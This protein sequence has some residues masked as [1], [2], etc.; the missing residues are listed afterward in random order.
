MAT[1][2]FRSSIAA[3]VVTLW[4]TASAMA[5]D[6]EPVDVGSGDILLV[7]SGAFTESDDVTDLV[8]AVSSHRPIAVTFNSPGGNLYSAM[9]HGRMIRA[10]GLSTIQG[11]DLECV[12]AC[13]LAFLGGVHRIAAPGSIGVHR[14]SF[15]PGSL[16][17]SDEATAA[18]QQ[19][20]A[21][22]LAFLREMD[23]D[24][25]LLQV[26]MEYDNS[27][28]RYLSASE[29]LRMRVITEASADSSVAQESPS[30][31][32]DTPLSVPQPDASRDYR[33]DA[34]S[35][36]DGIISAHTLPAASGLAILSRGYSDPAS[37]FGEVTSLG[38]IM[39]DKSSYFD[40]WP[41]RSYQVRPHQT[42]VECGQRMC[43][44]R[45]TYD[46]AVRSVPRN[47]HA[48]GTATFEFV[49]DMSQNGLRIVR[50]SSS[51]ISRN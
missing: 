48:S 26:S 8:A 51:V 4:A 11:R 49:V 23:V 25:E 10:L 16:L 22:I 12:S 21:Q 27:D 17:N 13:S 3:L 33:A 15:A 2:G 30:L 20:T 5:L 44:V 40:R 1:A 47:R 28:M 45:G 29:M 7:I 19:M 24:S 9:L 50:E 31:Q 14:S 37:Y 36:V 38:D 32:P 35:F 34:L 6:Y 46:W 43:E 39:A 41:E 18:I 42:T